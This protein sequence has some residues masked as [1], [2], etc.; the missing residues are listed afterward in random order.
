MKDRNGDNTL[1]RLGQI[2]KLVLALLGFG[3]SDGISG[4]FG[5]ALVPLT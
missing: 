2:T 3:E 4:P 1:I 5:D